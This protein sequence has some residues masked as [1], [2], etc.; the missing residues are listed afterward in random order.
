MTRWIAPLS[1]VLP[2]FAVAQ[3][4]ISIPLH[5]RIVRAF[6]DLQ[7]VLG[8]LLDGPGDLTAVEFGRLGRRPKNE[9][10]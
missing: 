3:P 2:H 4:L 5:C 6:L 8:D 1:A 7:Y 10:I 9:Q